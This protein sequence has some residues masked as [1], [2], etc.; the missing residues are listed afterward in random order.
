MT[1]SILSVE[2]EERLR[3]LADINRVSTGFWDWGGNHQ[4]VSANTLLR[5]LSALGVPVDQDS[6]RDDIEAAIVWTNQKPWRTT[7]PEFTV[8]RQGKGAEVFVHVPDGRRVDVWVD[9]ECGGRGALQQLDWYFEPQDIDGRMVG[10]ATFR[11]DPGLPLGYHRIVASVE[12]PGAPNSIHESDLVV[13]PNRLDPSVLQPQGDRFWGVN[14]Q[15]Y[16][17]RGKNSWGVGDAADLADLTAICAAEDADFVLVNPLHAAEV[18]LPVEDS[19]Y[20][21]VSRR[22]L[23]LSYIRPEL[24]PEYATVGPRQKAR[25]DELR[26][27]AAAAPPTRGGGLNRD[28]T[29]EAK[30]QAL[31]I[32]YARP[33]S[34]SREALFDRFKEEHGSGLYNYSL[35]CA[36]TEHLGT[37]HLPDE[38]GGPEKPAVLALEP[39]LAGRIEFYSWCQWVA[40]KQ[41]HL[42]NRVGTDL[43]MRIGIMADLAVGVHRYGADYW[44]DPGQ[45]AQ[46]MTV[47]APPDMYS[48]QGQDWS[49]PPWNPRALER[50]GY[51]PLRE[52]L[53]AT[54]RLSGALRIDHILG[55]FRLWWIPEGERANRGTYVNF[56]H[57]AMVGVLL[58]EA[59]RHGSLVIGEDLG[60]V[61]PWVR[62]YLDERGV[63]GTSVLWFEKDGGGWPLRAD[64]YRPGVLA[65]VNT[66]D[67]PP[68]AGYMEGTHTRLRE[69]LGILV[70]PV[71]D[72]MEADVEEQRR[73]RER[74]A[75]MDLLPPDADNA[76][77]IEALH[78]FI[79]R[80]PSRL[81]AAA[82]V[83]AVGEKQPQ[84]LPGTQNEYPNWR[85]PLCDADGDPIW[86]EE[87]SEREDLRRLFG[88]MR[89]EIPH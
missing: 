71:E 80:T 61:E 74:L 14:V 21:P 46:E 47:G 68:T 75:E 45:F 85:V 69:E 37:S 3:H 60:T 16:S 53:A 13:V 82:L 59:H 35:W 43:G 6:T 81:V 34:I 55:L 70:D 36:L 89:E 66:H 31:E 27:R 63:L 56:D 2:D 48:Q 41:C 77:V 30:R 51:R 18:T 40:N 57:E 62:Q 26:E 9:L 83:D 84:N 12:E 50:A 42:P 7:L 28:T 11:I 22:W 76:Q 17:V 25:I 23:N 86:L 38:Y 1:D 32:I 54:M 5:V 65:T 4:N 44:S 20:L 8:I 19:P 33:R 10:R 64:Q 87:L 49:Q 67:L 15:A 72:V 39:K 78:R 88:V 24:V 52:V 73:I 58:L 29:W 79:C